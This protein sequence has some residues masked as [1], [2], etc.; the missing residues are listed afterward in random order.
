[1]RAAGLENVEIL[2]IPGAHPYVYG[3]WLHAAGAPT[4]LLY[5]HHDVQ[6]P[7]REEKWLSPAFKPTQRGERLYGRGTADDKAG[8][9]MHLAAL[10]AYL[11]TGK[12]L[13]VNVRFFI[14]G[15][16][17]T[18]SEH[19]EEF[20]KTY[21][22]RLRADVM[23]LT[24]TANLDVGLPSIT[25]RLRGLVD[26]V[27]EVRTLDHPVHS[28][29][30]GGPALDALT[31]LSQIL[32]RLLTP[33]GRIAIP[34]F[35][36]GIL[37]VT[38]LEKERI[39]ALPFDENKFRRELGCVSGMELGGEKEFTVYERLWCRPSIAV[40]GIDAPSVEKT[41]NQIVE[42]ARAKVSARIVNGM[43]PEKS[44]ARLCAF[45]EKDPPFGTEVKVTAG[46]AGDPWRID[47]TGPVYEAAVRALKK[48]FERDPVFI[49]CGGSI[50]F[51]EP[52]TKHF[53][54]I[55]AL[56]M[57]IED[58]STNAHGE[59]ESL[60]LPDFK[61]SILSA[62]HLYAELANAFRS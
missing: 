36:E 42:A 56:L 35:Y 16:E 13:P 41:S 30:W 60:Y 22:A 14:E 38:G 52:L 48:G 27:V 17:E 21:E 58:P 12:K 29:L 34:D 61:K 4:I 51:V 15:E 39:Y 19:L 31:A 7:G 54:G 49:G 50:P 9:L 43:N 40:L 2:T 44:L 3:D 25:Y 47:P 24:D 45:L 62:V 11:Q 55:P 18:G 57:G 32:S 46:K 1:M 23:V 10:E 28:G 20:L 53:G 59:N 33:K 5:A 8:G 6:P 37:P 26:A